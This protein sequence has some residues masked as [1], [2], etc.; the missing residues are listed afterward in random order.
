VDILCT[1]ASLYFPLLL[2]RETFIR[3]SAQ[4]NLQIS[5]I[6]YFL[7]WRVHHSHGMFAPWQQ[8]ISLPMANINVANQYHFF[9]TNQK[10]PDKNQS[11][12]I[13]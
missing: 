2:P 11:P 1:S 7:L 10:N 9:K 5:E 12:S 4:N 6:A 8:G 3:L 13:K